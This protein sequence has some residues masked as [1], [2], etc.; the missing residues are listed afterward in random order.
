MHQAEEDRDRDSDNTRVHLQLA[1][2][3][4]RRGLTEHEL[5]TPSYQAGP[6]VVLLDL[7][8]TGERS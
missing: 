7:N 5:S 3:G 4:V 6:L 8:T 2:L 1:E